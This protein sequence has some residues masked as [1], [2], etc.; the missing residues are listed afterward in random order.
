MEGEK[1]GGKGGQGPVTADD[2]FTACDA[3]ADG[4]L[5]KDEVH[6]CVLDQFKKMGEEM[7]AQVDEMW[8]TVDTNSDTF[9]SKE[10]L[11]AA[12]SY[13]Q[14]E[15]E[16]RSEESGEEEGE[17]KGKKGGKKGGKRD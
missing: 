5:T 1:K 10:E 11:E 7:N 12:M 16:E 6:T 15:G 3:D 2:L 4:K 8:S 13:G 14:G 17:K 9:I